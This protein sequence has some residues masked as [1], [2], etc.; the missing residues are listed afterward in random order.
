MEI[1]HIHEDPE[2]GVDGNSHTWFGCPGKYSGKI[3]EKYLIEWMSIEKT[4]RDGLNFFRNAYSY[5]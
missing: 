3:L 2:V 4:L 1:F 5:F